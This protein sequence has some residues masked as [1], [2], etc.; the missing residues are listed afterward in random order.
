F[1]QGNLVS[2]TEQ[3]LAVAKIGFEQI[4]FELAQNYSLVYGILAV[5]L[6]IFTGWLA[7]VIFRKD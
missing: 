5:T 6:A 3:T 1:N 2:Q 4:T 7:G